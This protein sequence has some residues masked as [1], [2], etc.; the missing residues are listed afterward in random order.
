MLEDDMKMIYKTKKTEE[1]D[2]AKA[3]A[4]AWLVSRCNK[5]VLLL[6]N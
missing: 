6:V 4:K 5:I 2:A 3:E 1:L